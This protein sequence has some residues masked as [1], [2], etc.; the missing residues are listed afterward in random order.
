M[1]QNVCCDGLALATLGTMHAS[2]GSI[3]SHPWSAQFIHYFTAVW[4]PPVTTVIQ[5]AWWKGAYSIK[6][7]LRTCSSEISRALF[8]IWPMRSTGD[9]L[10]WSAPFL[11]FG[12]FRYWGELSMGEIVADELEH[13][14][15]SHFSPVL[16]QLFKQNILHCIFGQNIL[17][18]G[19]AF[20]GAEKRL[21]SDKKTISLHFC[22]SHKKS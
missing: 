14:Y 8:I 3:S 15:C 21:K 17:I 10:T 20:Q 7:N 4:L 16:K 18:V 9:S 11:N 6:E 2:R 5:H 12:N 1:P 19:R 22:I 13:F